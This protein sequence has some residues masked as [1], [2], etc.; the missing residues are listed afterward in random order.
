MTKATTATKVTLEEIIAEN[1][2]TEESIKMAKIV[3]DQE[4]IADALQVTSYM[5]SNVKLELA[6]ELVVRDVQI[7]YL[8]A[9]I[10]ELTSESRQDAKMLAL[11]R[12]NEEMQTATQKRL[13]EAEK[14]E[15]VAKKP[16]KKAEKTT[17]TKTTKKATKKSK[18]TA[19]KSKAVVADKPT[20]LT[21]E[22]RK[23][24]SD[25]LIVHCAGCPAWCTGQSTKHTVAEWSTAHIEKILKSVAKETPAKAKKILAKHVFVN[26]PREVVTS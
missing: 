12:A 4:Q 10:D 6:K 17:A 8:R 2:Q 1:T 15:I 22:E 21:K 25:A 23:A 20:K 18:K 16:A 19:T 13:D 5:K 24:I 26:G 7:D 3:S 9:R 14:A 11:V